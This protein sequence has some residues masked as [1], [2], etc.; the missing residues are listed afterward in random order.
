M[1]GF[2]IKCRGLGQ[3]PNKLLTNN[4]KKEIIWVFNLQSRDLHAPAALA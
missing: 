2:I 1:V 4:Y 3:S